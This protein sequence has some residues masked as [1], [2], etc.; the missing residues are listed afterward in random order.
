MSFVVTVTQTFPPDS[1]AQPKEVLRIDVETIDLA[2]VF[3]AVNFKKR[4]RKPRAAKS[5]RLLSE[6]I[7]TP[8][9]P[10]TREEKSQAL[11]S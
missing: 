9:R 2:R 4:E 5:E 8:L 6:S 3:A 1:N 10:L 7:V 11:N